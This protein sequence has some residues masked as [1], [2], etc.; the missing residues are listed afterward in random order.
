MALKKNSWFKPS[1]LNWF[2]PS[3]K[4]RRHGFLTKFIQIP[5]FPLH[6]GLVLKKQAY[7]QCK[8]MFK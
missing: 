7:K 1:G 2:K 6:S 4:T 5:F 3:L 8:E